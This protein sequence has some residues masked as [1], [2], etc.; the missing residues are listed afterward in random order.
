[1]ANPDNIVTVNISIADAAVSKT[2][3]GTPLIMTHEAPYTPELVREYTATAD[4]VTDGF[5]AAGATVAAATAILAQNPKVTSLKVG[6]RGSTASAMTRIMTVAT[7]M[8]DTDYTVTINGTAFTIDSGSSAT[9]ITIA[10]ALVA[11]INAG[12]EPVTATDNLDGTFDLVEDT[13]G[14]IFGLTHTLN[15]ITQDD[16]TTDAGVAADYAAIKAEDNDFYAVFM[17]SSSTL[18][19]AAL[20]AAVEADTKIFVAQ[21]ADS[22][23]LADTAGNLAETLEVAGYNRTA[24]LWNMDNLEYANGA[25]CGLQLSKNPGSST[26]AFKS[27]SGVSTDALSNTQIS[28]LESNDCNHYTVTKGLSWVLQGTMASGR[29]IDITRGIDW[30]EAEIQDAALN[31]KANSEK[32]PYTQVGVT[33]LENV[34]RGALQSGVSN[35]VINRDYTITAPIASEQSTADRVARTLDSIDFTATLAGAIHKVTIN[36]T[37]SA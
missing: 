6:I 27:L 8:D 34:L 14:T 10:A 20:A 36:G 24:L 32:I 35:D 21:T 1:M 33:A 28:N 22:D 12:S 26:W 2:G 31:L 3:F 19:I 30:L 25:W 7:A 5:A 11:A 13:A 16:T 29:F 17:T 18:E 15:L 4:M 9:V 37:V 23:C